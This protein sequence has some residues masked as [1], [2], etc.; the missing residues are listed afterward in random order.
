MVGN[1]WRGLVFG[2]YKQGAGRVRDCSFSGNISYH[3]DTQQMGFGEL[4]IQWSGGNTVESNIFVCGSGDL[5]LMCPDSGSGEMNHLNHNIWHS[6]RGDASS[7]MFVWDAREIQGF[8]A[9]VLT[10]GQDAKGRFLN[11][12]FIDPAATNFARKPV[13]AAEKQGA[14]K[15]R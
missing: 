2:G 7:V 4:W 11:P 13:T 5:L 12:G 8:K 3:N 1:S 15:L 9:Y 10:T 6:E 14:K